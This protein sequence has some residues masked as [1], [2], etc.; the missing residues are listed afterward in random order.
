MTK[1]LVCSQHSWGK[2]VFD[3][4]ITKLP[5]EWHFLDDLSGFDW[6]NDYRYIFFLHW[7]DKVREDI[8]SQYECVC[9]HPGR[10]PEERGGTPIQN[11]ISVGL[12]ET[13]LTAFR[14]TDEIDAGPVY[15]TE[16]LSLHGTAEEIYL[17]MSMEAY[18]MI[19]WL[20]DEPIDP[21]PQEG[22]PHVFS[23][24]TPDK[25]QIIIPYDLDDLFRKIRMLDAA[26][27]PRAY[28]VHNG[29][30]YTF[31]RPTMR[32]GKLVCDVEITELGEE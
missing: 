19:E 25:S 3:K 7:S 13:F 30:K 18:Y 15:M 4:Y 21:L 20:I 28:I 31:S 29:F 24:R 1:Y 27:Y 23:R 8:T 2:Y 10:L 12:D 5:G 22:D 26:G 17:R 32:V 9:F 16:Y 14:M 11:L 6:S